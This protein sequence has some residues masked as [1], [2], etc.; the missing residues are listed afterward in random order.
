MGTA[1][2]ARSPLRLALAAA[3]LALGVG[4]AVAQPTAAPP[5]EPVPVA[6][7]APPGSS[8]E[9][10]VGAGVGVLA[11]FVLLAFILGAGS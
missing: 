2:L 4:A 3:V 10:A 6:A 5:A 1:M 9:V 8:R 7:D 11:G